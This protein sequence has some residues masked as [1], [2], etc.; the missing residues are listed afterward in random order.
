MAYIGQPVW[1]DAVEFDTC[2][3]LAAVAK[4]AVAIERESIRGFIARLKW[5]DTKEL[6]CD[7]ILIFKEIEAYAYMTRTPTIKEPSLQYALEER[8]MAYEGWLSSSPSTIQHHENDADAVTWWNSLREYA[9]IKPEATMSRAFVERLL[10][11][12][13]L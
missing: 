1:K 8:I 13:S 5:Q 2:R 7:S 6:G 3:R 11:M 12:I 9:D 10:D 4:T